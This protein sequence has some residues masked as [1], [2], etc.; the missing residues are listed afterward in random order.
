MNTTYR[1]AFDKDTTGGI[2]LIP[3]TD[4]QTVDNLSVEV[5]E[6]ITEPITGEEQTV[7]E[8]TETVDTTEFQTQMLKIQTQQT[9]LLLFV[10][11]GVMLL[12]GFILARIVWRKL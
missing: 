6:A 5:E 8:T 2:R 1:Y 3:V 7:E 12:N 10:A 11:F 4:V 9:Y